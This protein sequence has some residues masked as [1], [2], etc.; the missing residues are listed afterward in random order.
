MSRGASELFVAVRVKTTVLRP[1]MSSGPSRTSSTAMCAFATGR[2][3][4]MGSS[5][6]DALVEEYPG[7]GSSGGEA[8]RATR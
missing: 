2:S 4:S 3:A 8:T 6:W 1:L 7:A 5:S